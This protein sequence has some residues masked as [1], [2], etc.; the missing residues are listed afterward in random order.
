MIK[1]Y[2]KTEPNYSIP[3]RVN[4]YTHYLSLLQTTKQQ[5]SQTLPNTRSVANT[6]TL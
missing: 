5:I 6:D 4:S 2:T 3:A 1:E